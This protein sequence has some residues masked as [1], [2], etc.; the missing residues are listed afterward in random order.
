MRKMVMADQPQLGVY[1]LAYICGGPTRVITVAVL[2]L[3]DDEQIAISRA[4]HRVRII[5]R[6]PRDRVESA[7]LHAIPDSGRQ[8]GSLTA[9]A[10]DSDAVAEIGTALREQ[11]I[12]PRSPWQISRIVRAY[13]LRRKLRASPVK[14][15][16]EV[17]ILGPSGIPDA[18]VRKI[19]ETPN[20]HFQLPDLKLPRLPDRNDR[21]YDENADVRSA[22]RLDIYGPGGSGWGL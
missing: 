7:V 8:L 16:N 18:A 1:D 3:A 15:I 2:A 6:T 10:A 21:P 12:L 20:P 14:G 19:F 22:A 4:L 11:R 13:N 5:R 17:A 9:A